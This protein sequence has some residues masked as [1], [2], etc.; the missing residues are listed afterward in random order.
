MD[1]SLL[2]QIED[3]AVF[4]TV[5]DQGSFS[6][7]GRKLGLA[8]SAISKRVDRLE[9]ALGLRLLQRSTR[10]LSVTEAGRAIHERAAQSI[11]LLEEARNHASNLI[12]SPRGL[13]KVTTSVAFGKL[14][15]APLL[16]EFL[17]LFPE[18]KIQ[19]TLL[20]RTVD[21]VE[22]GFDLAIRL[23]RSPPGLLVAKP[24][25]PIEYVLC[26]TPSYI[27]GKRLRTPADLANLNCL[28]Y[29]QQELSQAWSFQKGARK[30]TVKVSGNIVVNSSE[31]V[32]DLMLQNVGIGL[33]ARYAVADELS[34]GSLRV[35]LPSW[36]ATGLF[37][38]TAFAVWRPQIHLPQKIRV[39]VDFLQ[40]RLAQ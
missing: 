12:E 5:V 23:T 21:L 33:V 32:R 1:K 22:E 20:D 31:V 36:K 3:I 28:S 16:S 10:S 40:A 14:C 34:K 18:I 9:R 37:A 8:K 19:L 4:A 24:L 13:I 2:E 35:L 6:G 11:S 25:M 7:A 17:L 15:I 39:F 29:G 27:N 38:Q 26:A 30:E